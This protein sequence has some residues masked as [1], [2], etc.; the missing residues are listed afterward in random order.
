MAPR[1]KG[2]PKVTNLFPRAAPHSWDWHTLFSTQNHIQRGE[3]PNYLH[4]FACFIKCYVDK[5][6]LSLQI[7]QHVKINQI[8]HRNSK[9]FWLQ[10]DCMMYP[11]RRQLEARL[12][13][14][15]HLGKQYLCLLTSKDWHG[16]GMDTVP[17]LAPPHPVPLLPIPTLNSRNTH[18][19]NEPK[20]MQPKKSKKRKPTIFFYASIILQEMTR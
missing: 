18:T 3:K 12:N 8:T 4:S 5:T 2:Y 19:V 1:V 7:H 16:M 17:S 14:K 20:K 9:I 10:Q 13:A 15:V 11:R 6:V